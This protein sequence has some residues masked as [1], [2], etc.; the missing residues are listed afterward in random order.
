MFDIERHCQKEVRNSRNEYKGAPQ[1]Q[2]IA[3]VAAAVENCVRYCI[4]GHFEQLY[5]VAV[6]SYRMYC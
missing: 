4:G 6:E 3:D 1:L 5:E 2:L